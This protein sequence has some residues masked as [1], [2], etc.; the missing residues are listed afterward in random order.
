MNHVLGLAAETADG[1]SDLV[2]ELDRWAE[3]GSTA[4]LWWRDDDAVTATQQLDQLLQL[5]GAV[6]L[7]LAAIPA[8]ALPELA[9]ALSG[10]AG[11]A[12]LQHGWQHANRAE[13]GKKSEYPEGR[14]ATVV[15]VEIAAGRARLRALFGRCVVPIFVPPWNRFAPEHLPRL[16][17]NG[18][19]ALSTMAHPS[20]PALPAGLAAIDVHVDLVNWRGDRGFVGTRPALDRLISQLQARRQA[21]AGGPIGILTHHRIIDGATASFLERLITLTGAHSGCRWAAAAEF[22]A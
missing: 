18:I 13:G 7:A 5:A 20:G 17:E 4:A 1:W 16:V 21:G 15:G 10:A 12:V 11:V 22:L 3:A 9:A 2:D 6:P 19:A 8:L 14:S